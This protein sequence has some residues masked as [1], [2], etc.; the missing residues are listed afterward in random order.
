M[1]ICKNVEYREV[2]LGS[3]HRITSYNVCY[4]KLLRALHN[5]A[6]TTLQNVTDFERGNVREENRVGSAQI[7]SATR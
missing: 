2:R 3:G 5:I 7:A 1:Q 4:T 6:E